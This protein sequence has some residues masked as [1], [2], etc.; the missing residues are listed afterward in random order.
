MN[1]QDLISELEDIKK[2]YGDDVEVKIYG[3]NGEYKDFFEFEIETLE[4]KTNLY[5]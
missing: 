4:D 2:A 5:L 3:E 1:I